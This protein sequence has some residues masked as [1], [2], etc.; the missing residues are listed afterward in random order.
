MRYLSNLCPKCREGKIFRGIMRMN[1]KCPVCGN[2]FEK[3]EGYFIG[4][5]IASYFISF[6]LAVPVFL[7]SVFVFELEMPFALLLVSAQLL[8]LFPILFRFSRLVWIHIESDLTKSI[9]R[10]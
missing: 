5:M 9:H 2:V 8:I 1:S 7:L 6:F 10:S 3:E 4:A